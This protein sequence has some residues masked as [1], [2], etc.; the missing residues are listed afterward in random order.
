MRDLG[1]KYLILKGILSTAVGKKSF[2]F[3]SEVAKSKFHNS[4]FV[5]LES[6]TRY[7]YVSCGASLLRLR[8][9]IKLIRKYLNEL[10]N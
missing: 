2:G 6:L 5:S 4:W 1:F 3:L 9:T 7:N 8:F 10:I